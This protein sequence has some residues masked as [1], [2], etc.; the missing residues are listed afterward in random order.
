M[1]TK[2]AYKIGKFKPYFR[3]DFIDF[4]EGDPFFTSIE[5]DIIKDTL[6]I[7]WDWTTFSAIKMEY[8]FTDRD[9]QDDI[10]SLALG[11]SF[12]F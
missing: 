12:T 8:S 4:G 3:L 7:R 1:K 11:I 10:N 9:I 5:E 2:G 6:G